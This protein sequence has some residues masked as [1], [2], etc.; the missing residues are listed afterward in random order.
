[1]LL[2]KKRK[3]DAS[4]A[5]SSADAAAATAKPRKKQSSTAATTAT[6]AAASDRA[7]ARDGA[8][9]KRVS[10]RSSARNTQKK[11]WGNDFAFEH[12]TE[13]LD[14]ETSSDDEST[15]ASGEG[16]KSFMCKACGEGFTTNK[17]LKA[18]IIKRKSDKLHASAS[19][20][21]SRS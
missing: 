5:S 16:N 11:G 13:Y 9:S 4:N 15:A 18:H 10:G 6:A 3:S 2:S 12:D 7:A 8:S 1:M 17:R 20:K 14:D 19:D 21:H